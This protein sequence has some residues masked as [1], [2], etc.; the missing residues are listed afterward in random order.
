MYI[1]DYPSR[2]PWWKTIGVLIVTYNK[3]ERSRGFACKRQLV[4]LT[5]GMAYHQLKD[6]SYGMIWASY[7]LNGLIDKIKSTDIFKPENARRQRIQHL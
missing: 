5:F 1:A 4:A 2:P 6:E 7:S 3:V